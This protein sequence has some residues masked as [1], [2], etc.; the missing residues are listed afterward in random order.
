M[1]KITNRKLL[2]LARLDLDV[3][4]GPRERLNADSERHPGYRNCYFTSARAPFL[5]SCIRKIAILLA[6]AH[7]FWILVFAKWFFY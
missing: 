7:H 3:G 2:V 5:D 1:N 4:G 6:P